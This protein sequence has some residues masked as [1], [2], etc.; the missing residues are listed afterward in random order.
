ML[1]RIGN[2]R[3]I[4][5]VASGG[6]AVVYRAIQDELNRTV[7]IKAL[8]TSVAKEEHLAARFEREARS[9][10]ALQH[11]NIVHV[12]DFHKIRG[13]HFIVMEYVEGTDL[14]D[15]LDRCGRLPYDVAAV[16]AMQVARAIDYIHFHGIL[17]RDIKPANIMLS[18]QGA[19]KLMDF[20]IAQDKN[21]EDLTEI[22]TGIGTPSYMSPEQIVGDRLD[23]RSDIFSLG[24]VLY[25]M[26][27]GRKPFV[28]DDQQTVMQKIRL[29]PHQSARKVNPEIPRVLDRIIEKCLDKEAD[30]RF[31]SAQALVMALEKFLAKHVEMNYHARLVL[32][33]R[34]QKIIPAY[35]ANEYLNPTLGGRLVTVRPADIVHQ[36][37]VRRGL[38]FHG[39][40]L[41]V[42][43]LMVGLIHLAPIG[44]VPVI[45]PPATG[46]V[47]VIVNPWAHISIDGKKL[48]TTP[49]AK[50]FELT[51]GTH[52]LTISHDFLG[53]TEQVIEVTAGE[54]SEPE[55][56]AV[57][58]EA[59]K[60]PLE[61]DPDEAPNNEPDNKTPDNK[62]PDNKTPDKKSSA[63][64]GQSD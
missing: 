40:I 22:G 27:T 57:D 26:A 7:A 25:Q 35:E 10:A 18:R 20:G 11:E 16:I 19:V 49:L 54:E 38:V 62:T 14:Y 9:L 24:I 59:L 64:K 6:M 1:D 8:K 47:R 2:C 63:E 41:A 13:A 51:Q 42:I 3:I 44:S 29:E 5:E 4:E 30:D 15:L 32:F 61:A 17:H 58:L 43:T 50:P 39:I 53:T 33:L 34:D 45:A 36:R 31:G 21:Y 12:Y 55:V 46:Y 28:E 56:V 60:R 37:V 23:A 48:G 52:V